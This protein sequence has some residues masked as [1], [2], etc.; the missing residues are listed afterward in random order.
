MTPRP[1]N[2][3][4]GLD[5]FCRDRLSIGGLEDLTL[6]RV[7]PEQLLDQVDVSEQHAAA[8]VAGES[9][10]VERL[11][12]GCLRQHL[13]PDVFRILIDIPFSHA[14]A[15]IGINQLDVFGP[16]VTD[17]L[18]RILS[19]SRANLEFCQDSCSPCRMR[20]SARE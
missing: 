13:L 18:S 5:V 16:K 11:T 10:F 3:V 19:V 2:F 8:A 15:T 17:D 1:L 7:V 20:S 14:L 12:V 6:G 9:Q 4:S